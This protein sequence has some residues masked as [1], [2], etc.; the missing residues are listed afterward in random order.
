M[1]RF[2]SNHEGEP[3]VVAVSTLRHRV[4]AIGHIA[5][6]G[7]DR[8]SDVAIIHRF[9][10]MSHPDFRATLR[11]TE[12][13]IVR[14]DT[15][16]SSELLALAPH[17][18]II[19]RAGSGLDNIDVQSALAR[20]IIIVRSSGGNASSAAEHTL[21]LMLALAHRVVHANNSL[22]S[23]KWDRRRYQGTE[24]EGKTVGIVGLGAVGSRVAN[25]AHGLAMSVIA[26]DPIVSNE[27]ARRMG[28]EL[29]PI[30]TVIELADVLTLHVPLTPETFHLIGQDE[31]KR[32]AP[33]S[34]II[35]A[36]RGGVVDE[37]ALLDSLD[38]GNV[39][40]AG[41][42]VFECEPPIKG[43]L[44]YRLVTHPLVIATPHLGGY[45]REAQVAVAVDVCE[46]V[47]LLLVEREVIS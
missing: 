19:A 13:I 31:F 4:L 32:L 7:L 20:D 16:I 35:N 18:R 34:F 28:V 9:D 1:T 24:L 40:G 10:S 21:A 25:R 45:T 12:A 14:S 5:Q 39:A 17:L 27:S 11:D 43:S 30:E 2:Q 38:N 26:T 46:Q 44:S 33:S 15:A 29:R 3:H 47:R 36:A 37:Q 22:K 23:G 6:E 42:D 41:I 8:L